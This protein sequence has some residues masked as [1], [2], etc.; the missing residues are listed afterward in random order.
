MCLAAFLT[1]FSCSFISCVFFT[2]AKKATA[3]TYVPILIG[4]N[5]LYVGLLV[6]GFSSLSASSHYDGSLPYNGTKLGLLGMLFTWIQQGYAYLGIMDDAASRALAPK[7]SKG[8]VVGI[9]FYL[10]I[11]SFVAQFFSLFHSQEWFYMNI[12]GVVYKLYQTVYGKNDNKKKKKKKK[13]S[14]Y[15]PYSDYDGEIGVLLGD[16]IRVSK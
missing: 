13:T 11:F 9:H 2:A 15:G 14:P 4:V 3:K 6:L 5:I 16:K 7:R 8:L 10:L 1:C 12:V